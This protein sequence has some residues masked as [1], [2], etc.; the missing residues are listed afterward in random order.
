[1][2][3][4]APLQEIIKHY[5][6]A[7]KLRE[8]IELK[9]ERATNEYFTI[10]C[11][12]QNILSKYTKWTKFLKAPKVYFNILEKGKDKFIP[13]GGQ[14]GISEIQRGFTTGC[15]DFFLVRDVTDTVKDNTLLTAVNSKEYI[16]SIAE[17]KQ[18]KLRLVR[19]G[20]KELWL[21]ESQFLDLILTS[22]KDVGTYIVNPS[23]IM[24]RLL[25]VSEKKSVLQSKYPFVFE[26]I[27][28]AERKN[29]HLRS[30]LANRKIWYDI[31]KGKLPDMAFS[32]MI[33][34]FGKT[35]LANVYTND[36]FQNIFVKNNRKTVFLYLNSTISWFFQQLIIRTNF[37]DGVAKIQSYELA[38]MLIPSIDL[39]NLRVN[40][41]NTKSFKEELGDL[42]SLDSVNP[43]RVKLDSTILEAIGYKHKKEIDE[44]LLEMYRATY[45]LIE[46]RLLKA[47]SQKRVKSQ[48][49]KV[50]LISYVN[51]LKTMLIEGNYVAKNTLKF[52]KELEK[53]VDEISSESKLKK[54]ILDI[55]WKEKFGKV[56]NERQIAQQDQMSL[57]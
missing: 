44:V 43:E 39:E 12:E 31:G 23:K 32:Y 10:N 57:F 1:V 5:K 49:N 51:Q 8:T 25:K 24:Y 28:F 53:L 30:T 40:L 41:G 42:K 20:Y 29:I 6:S 13:L 17:A 4:T 35:Y 26:Y 16:T 54:K 38:D 48:R 56:F 2:Y 9:K 52:A 33:N 3:F 55:Y 27:Q 36:N 37:G 46:S 21:I 34:D 19:N 11:V 45:Q 50:E 47:Q 18:L 15:N 22:P 14:K 7:D